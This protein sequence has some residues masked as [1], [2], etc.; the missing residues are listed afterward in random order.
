MIIWHFSVIN[1]NCLYFIV[2]LIKITLII[3]NLSTQY[4]L[5][6]FQSPYTHETFASTVSDWLPIGRVLDSP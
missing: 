3:A 6:L 2:L 4:S 5:H 1:C